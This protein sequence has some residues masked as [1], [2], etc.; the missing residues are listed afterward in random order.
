MKQLV[1]AISLAT[2]AG[3]AV[4][5]LFLVAGT[6]AIIDEF[7]APTFTA[8]VANVPTVSAVSWQVFDVETGAVLL[9][10]QPET[11]RPIA[12]VTKLATGATVLS[13]GDAFATTTIMSTDVATAGRAGRLTAGETY[14]RHTLLFPLL[15]ESSNDAAAA[16]ERSEPE[17]M[18]QMNERA[19]ALGLTNTQFSDGSGLSDDNVSTAAELAT[20]LRAWYQDVRHLLDITSL[21]SYLTPETGWRNNSPF[22]DDPSYQGGKHGFTPTAGATATVLFQESLGG[23]TRTI[24]YVLLGSDDLAADTER[25]RQYVRSHVRL[26]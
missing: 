21:Q 3:L 16:L 14:P 10:H 12:S 8:T 6:V 17:L 19:S 7:S 23:S 13:Q 26:N 2:I 24:G 15:L 18:T 20:L 4:V 1:G 9:A 25:L 11:I 22:A 5:A